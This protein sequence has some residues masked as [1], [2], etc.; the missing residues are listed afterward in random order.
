MHTI[1]LFKPDDVRSEG[2]GP[3][4]PQGSYVVIRVF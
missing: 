2:I 3:I 4:R 1:I